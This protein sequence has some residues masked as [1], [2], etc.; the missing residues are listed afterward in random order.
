MAAFHLRAWYGKVRRSKLST[1]VTVLFAAAFVIPWCAYAWLTISERAEQ[2]QRTERMLAALAAAYG[3]HATTLISNPGTARVEE[4]L[5]AFRAALN[6]PGVTFSLRRSG[7]RA[8]TLALDDRNGMIVAEANRPSGGIVAAASMSEA[9]AL[10]DWRAGAYVQALALFVRSLFVVGV[11]WFL[12]RQLRWREATERELVMAKEKAESASRAKSE[13]L[14]NMSHE[15]RTPLNAIIG[16]AEIIKS[17]SFGSASERYSEYAGDIYNSGTHLLALIND[18]LNLSKLEAGKFQLQ[19]QNVDLA[20]TVGDC[21]RLIETQAHQSDI[22]LSVS[23]DPE[24]LFIRA[25]ERRLRQIL[26]NLLSNAVKFTAEGGNVSVKSARRNG[27]LA[28]SIIDTGIG[29]AAEDIPKAL[30]PFGQIERKVRRKQEGTGLGLPIAKQ[31]VELHGGTFAID[32]KLNSGTT[33][34]FL[35]PPSR[36]IASPAGFRAAG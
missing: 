9:E 24:A 12:V 6:V 1:R 31:F 11:G 23:L 27:G 34:T 33:V 4:E 35:L 28:I 30:A 5:T 22:R 2:V 32:S 14:A 20:V 18:I 25:D 26:I 16:F 13:F 19:E 36:M 7:E 3:Q 15:L 21:L 10:N 17:R 29:M 8:S